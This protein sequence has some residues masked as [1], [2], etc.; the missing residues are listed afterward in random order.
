MDSIDAGDFG[1]MCLHRKIAPYQCIVY[2]LCQGIKWLNSKNIVYQI[3]SKV[4]S[5]F[6]LNHLFCLDGSTSN[7]LKELV[8]Y[9]SMLLQ[10]S[11]ISILDANDCHF[12][13]NAALQQKFTEMDAIGIPYGILLDSDSLKTGFMKLRNRDTTLSESIHIGCLTE[14]LPKIFQS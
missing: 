2:S 9:V 11:N 8:K 4:E 7:D 3:E 14:Y 12:V 13:E 10:R 5:K 6:L 1:E